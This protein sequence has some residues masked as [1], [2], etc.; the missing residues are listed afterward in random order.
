M[1][2]DGDEKRKNSLEIK[3]GRGIDAA[4]GDV[5]R[6]LL[7]KPAKEAGN[8]FSDGI[9][10]LSDKMR[11]KREKNFELGMGSVRNTLED[12]NVDMK[13]ITP[14]KEEEL[15]LL[16]NGLSLTDDWNVRKMWAGLFA[17]ALEPNS[18]VTAERP[19]ISVLESLS[20]MDAKVID[21]LAFYQKT[22]SGLK[23][24][25]VKFEPKSYAKVTP[26]EKELMNSVIETNTALRQEAFEAIHRRAEKLDLTS[27]SQPSWA[28]NLMRQGIIERP[29][30]K[31]FWNESQT[32]F[33]KVEEN[34]AGAIRKLDNKFEQIEQD[35]KR[36]STEPKQIFTSIPAASQMQFEIQLTDFGKR[37]AEA[38]GLL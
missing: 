17:K 34:L 37:L 38:C 36:N 18:E 5:I 22:E 33:D 11:R 32:W 13:D 35:A 14:P 9:G 20:P 4:L 23:E 30:I 26:E 1:M 21:L 27:I 6:G 7:I 10:I 28:E 12:D 16:M 31:H 19:F 2:N 3:N 24:S 29:P 25:F 8:L 15:Y